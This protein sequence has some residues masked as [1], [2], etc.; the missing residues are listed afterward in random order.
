MRSPLALIPL[1]LLTPYASSLALADGKPAKP[2]FDLRASPPMAF[3]PARVLLVGELRG[4]DDLEE[5]YC[6]GIEWEWGDGDRSVQE[7][8]CPPFAAGVELPRR[9]TA[10][11]AYLSPGRYQVKLTLRRAD[12]SVAV[13][14]TP[15]LVH[16]RFGGGPE[17]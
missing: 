12:R 15:I 17:E 5:Y 2:R 4:G 10:S 8:D 7:S 3:S 13:A 6:P 1:L 16:S 14:T 9:F 11:H